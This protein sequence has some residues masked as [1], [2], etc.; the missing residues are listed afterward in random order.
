MSKLQRNC[1]HVIYEKLRVADDFLDNFKKNII[2]TIKERI[3][4][5][6]FEAFTG[7]L[8]DIQG[9]Y[10]AVSELIDSYLNKEVIDVFGVDRKRNI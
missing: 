8:E 3:V 1:L 10:K 4:E 2:E 6:P 5:Q 9:S 7:H